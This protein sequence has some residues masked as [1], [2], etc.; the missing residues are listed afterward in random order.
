VSRLAEIQ[1]Y[2]RKAVVDGDTTS[3]AHLLIGGCDAAKRLTVHQRN[4]QTSLIDSLLVKFPATGWLIGTPLLT[5][6]AKHFA[7][8]NP[9]QAP[10]IAEYGAAF[11][12]FL[13]QCPETQRL[14][15]LRKFAQLEWYVGQVSIAVDHAPVSGKEFSVIDASALLDTVLMLQSGLH[16][17]EASW[18]V[19]ELM[20]LYLTEKV[21]DYFELSPAD[22]W[23][24]VRGARGEFQLNRMDAASF[25]FRKSVLEG[26]SIGDAA[27]CALDINPGF[28]PGQALGDL[29]AEGL[30]TVIERNSTGGNS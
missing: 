19:D 4:Y 27:E 25:T 11:P 18:P 12:D 8:E 30:I 22:A 14:P 20:K 28:D 5:E 26:Y 24:E 2:F 17:I 1:S 10:C 6:A 7:R 3:V 15:Y 9:P 13:V 21:P 29:I 16:Y 23:I